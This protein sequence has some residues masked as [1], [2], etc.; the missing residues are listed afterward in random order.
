M[1]LARNLAESSM[2]VASF[3]FPHTTECMG[4]CIVSMQ[5]DVVHAIFID[6]SL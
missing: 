3:Y 4:Q 5:Y 1:R 6:T 2:Y